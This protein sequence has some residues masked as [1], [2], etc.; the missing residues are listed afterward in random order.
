M[1]IV[2]K[3]GGVTL[4]CTAFDKH[5]HGS[6]AVAYEHS[7]I[8]H[9]VYPT[10]SSALPIVRRYSRVMQTALMCADQYSLHSNTVCFK[11]TEYS[12]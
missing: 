8:L 9:S 11:Y 1:F 6:D 4:Y 7:S 2:V 10:V 12:V 3:D 5:T